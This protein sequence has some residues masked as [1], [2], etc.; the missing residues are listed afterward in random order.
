MGAK[1]RN[2]VWAAN[3]VIWH[4]DLGRPML[5]ASNV[6]IL[7]I[8][9]IGV[10]KVR[11]ATLA[12]TDSSGVLNTPMRINRP[13]TIMDAMYLPDRSGF[14]SCRGIV[15][16]RFKELRKWSENLTLHDLRLSSVSWL[17][18][19]MGRFSSTVPNSHL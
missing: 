15:I 16:S 6:N 8:S 13:L 7:A 2:T 4:C 18:W 12:K 19:S 11:T 17:M 14:L 10:A 1:I 5:V 9:F 3:P